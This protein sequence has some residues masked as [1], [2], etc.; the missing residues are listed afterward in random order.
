MLA[1]VILIAYITNQTDS[2]TANASIVIL[3]SRV[4]HGLV[5]IFGITALRG[6]C[7]V[8]SIVAMLTIVRSI[9]T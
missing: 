4:A 8:T 3:V 7:Y 6:L 2:T 1:I 5:Y 9:V